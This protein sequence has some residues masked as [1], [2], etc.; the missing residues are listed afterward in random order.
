MT[1][2]SGTPSSSRI[3]STSSWASRSWMTRVRPQPPGQVDVPA[4]R[5]LLGGP[6]LLPGPEVVEPGLADR[7]D[8]LARPRPAPRSRPAPRR[9]RPAPRAAAPRWGAARPPRRSRRA[10][11]AASTAQRA[12][13]R[14]QPICTIRV[15]PTA[16]AC[17]SASSVVSQRRPGR[18]DRRRCRGGSG[19]PRP[20]AAA[21]PAPEAGC[22]RGRRHGGCGS[23]RSRR[24]LRAGRGGLVHGV[25]DDPLGQP[26]PTGHVEDRLLARRPRRLLLGDQRGQRRRRPWVRRPGRRAPRRRSSPRPGHRRRPTRRG[27]PAR[28]GVPPRGSWSAPGTRR[29]GG[30]RRT[31]RPSRP[32]RPRCGAAPRRR[33]SS[34]A[35][36]AARP[37]ARPRSPA[38]RGRKP[39]KQNRS[40]GSPETASAVSTADGPGTAV[41]VTP[42]LDRGG[43]EPVAR[44]GHRR[45]PGVGDQQHPLAAE[46]RVHEHRG[47]GRLVALE[48]GDDPAGRASPRGRWSA[49]AAGGCPRRR[50]R[51]RWRAP[52]PA[53]A[54]RRRPGRWA[55]PASTSTPSPVARPALPRPS[56]DHPGTRRG[57]GVP[58]SVQ[59]R[60]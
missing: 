59:W 57:S 48:V 41:T 44:V 15:T 46:Q 33:P 37:A 53:A 39:S 34:A 52:R 30:R 4:E 3:R 47:A 9:A 55:S 38:L 24:R 50:P 21:A 13:G 12:P 20:G 19:C 26:G 43:D 58:G 54:A 35:R 36:R 31:P 5:Q 1:N 22:G 8:P 25:V 6:A 32:A 14:S 45:H 16:A 60:A 29:R 23:V 51:R 49:V 42:A 56:G 27:R 11:R 7:A 18:P 10:S 28:P 40:T 2:R 17:A